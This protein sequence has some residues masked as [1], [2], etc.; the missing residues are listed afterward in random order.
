MPDKAIDEWI[1]QGLQKG[2][3]REELTAMLANQGYDKKEIDTESDN[4]KPTINR[5][6][7]LTI[8]VVLIAV[9]ISAGL[10]YVYLT[11]HVMVYEK[12]SPSTTTTQ[13][14]SSQQTIQTQTP[15]QPTFTAKDKIIVFAAH[16]DDETIGT[17]TIM[18]RAVNAGD[19]VTVVITTDGAP[20]KFGQGRTEAAIRENET[21]KAMKLIG[22]PK[23]N[24]IFL[25]Y[26]D[27]GFIFEINTTKEVDRIAQLIKDKQPTQIYMQAYEGGHIDHDSTHLLVDEAIKKSG[28]KAKAYEFPEYNAFYWGKPIPTNESV[29]E[30]ES[31]PVMVLNLTPEEQKM[32]KEALKQYISQHPEKKNLVDKNAGPDLRMIN[33]AID[34][35]GKNLDPKDLKKEQGYLRVATVNPTLG[36]VT[37]TDFGKQEFGDVITSE[38][39]NFLKKPDLFLMSLGCEKLP[40]EERNYVF[41]YEN[42]MKCSIYDFQKPCNWT[43]GNLIHI[44]CFGEEDRLQKVREEEQRIQDSQDYYQTNYFPQGIPEDI[45]KSIRYGD[46]YK[47]VDENMTNFLGTITAEPRSKLAFYFDIGNVLDEEVDDVRVTIDNQEFGGSRLLNRYEVGPFNISSK[48]LISES[49]NIGIPSV[50]DEGLYD[51]KLSVEGKT[52]DNMTKEADYFISLKIAKEDHRA[53]I[54]DIHQD[55]IV[56]YNASWETVEDIEIDSAS[57]GRENTTINYEIRAE[58]PNVLYGYECYDPGNFCRNLIAYQ[59]FATI[60]RYILNVTK[61]K[62]EYDL[63]VDLIYNGTVMD[64]K[65]VKLIVDDKGNYT[66]SPYKE[67]DEFRMFYLTQPHERKI[68]ECNDDYLVCL[69]YWP[70]M[71]RE[72]PEYNYSEK[73]HQTPPNLLYEQFLNQSG[74]NITYENFK[75]T[76][77]KAEST[78]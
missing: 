10:Y 3:S 4:P 32:K 6:L 27:L 7:I 68:G 75:E 12:Q 59:D 50:I 23:E 73:P 16:E 8:I 72:M 70:D 39:W 19:A 1:K 5:A 77:E 22:V 24:V 61:V 31:K 46:Y 54:L 64:T 33:L 74:F 26:D 43:E 67:S 9:I 13:I 55:R 35:N 49:I 17:A 47:K 11:K 69:Y 56:R 65:K 44:W 63:M 40:V 41:G 37:L 53:N 34:I 38:T 66:I 28:V 48:M 30:A 18:N 14:P 51:I 62:G 58:Q 36:D 21:L 60:G 71:I 45:N 52:R 57:I 25:N 2:Y 78:S 15:T 20:S 42:R 29:R 76:A